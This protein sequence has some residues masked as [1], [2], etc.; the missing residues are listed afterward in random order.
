MTITWSLLL[1]LMFCCTW[2]VKVRM[3]MEGG[4]PGGASDADVEPPSRGGR[5]DQEILSEVR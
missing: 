4:G 3:H 1:R 2:K 5:E